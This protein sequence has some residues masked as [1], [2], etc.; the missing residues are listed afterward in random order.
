M[1]CYSNGKCNAK[2]QLANVSGSYFLAKTCSS[3]ESSIDKLKDTG[4]VRSTLKANMRL[5]S[6]MHRLQ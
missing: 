2:V 5:R 6:I 1:T 4:R 3:I